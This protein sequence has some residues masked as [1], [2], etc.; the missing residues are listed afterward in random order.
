MSE[1]FQ[2]W[3]DGY[4]VAFIETDPT[5]SNIPK[6]GVAGLFED[7]RVWIHEFTEMGIHEWMQRE[8][9]YISHRAS[10][11]LTSLAVHSGMR[12]RGKLVMIDPEEYWKRTML[13]KQKKLSGWWM[14][15]DRKSKLT[16]T[17]KESEKK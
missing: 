4:W 16:Q 1:V 11:I 7:I 17:P 10:H 5:F 3:T 13:G 6:Y 14:P 12:V 9:Y 2:P 8:Y 15:K